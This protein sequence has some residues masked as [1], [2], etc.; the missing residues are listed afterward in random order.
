MITRRLLVASATAALLPGQQ[1]DE[2]MF[3]NAEAYERFM[4]RWS[5]QIAPLLID[6]AAV[7][8][9]GHVLDIG[10]GTGALASEIARRKPG[11]HVTGIDP[12]PEYVGYARS[13]NPFPARITFHIGD[14]QKMSFQDATFAA[15]LSMLVFNFIPDPE[16]AL[17]EA[18]RV[19]KPN[20]R[21]AAAVWDYGDGMR[22]LRA[23]WDAAAEIDPAAERLDEKH[24]PLCRA[25]ELSRLWTKGGL[26]NVKEQP[27]ETEMKF[28]SFADY[29]E[30]FL[31]GQG[32]AG[33]YV[34]KLDPN[35]L[36]ALRAAVQRRVAA[37]SDGKPFTLR[38]RV[39]AVRGDAPAR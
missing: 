8:D 26:Q 36:Q 1:G 17:R 32:P 21:I 7:E 5:R 24:M 29:W 13:K 35:R 28:T 30:P 25:G 39:W 6:L 34:R 27:L 16:K 18:R 2:K 14:A 12:S 20:G 11:V 15:S 3:G 31:L 19:T 33:A 10:S 37:T 38:A 23:F 9:S 22:M 4:G